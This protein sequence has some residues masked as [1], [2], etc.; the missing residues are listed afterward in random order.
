MADKSLAKAL[1]R[2]MGLDEGIL[3]EVETKRGELSLL[4]NPSRRRIFEFICNYPCSHLRA[5]S[6]EV[7]LST[8]SARWHINKLKEGGLISE[9]QDGSKKIYRPLKNIFMPDECSVFCLLS[10]EN[11]RNT[12]LAIEA[13]PKITQSDLCKILGTYQ[14]ILSR[15]L[16][17]LENAGII[18]YKKIGRKKAYFATEKIRELEE[19]LDARSKTFERALIDALKGDSLNPKVES[20]DEN[21]LQISLDI[22]R[23]EKPVLKIPKNPL[24]VLLRGG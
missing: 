3:R 8:Q 12:Y 20:S 1:R 17:S 9:S 14:Q 19:D 11:T 23:E 4:M 2:K 22:D 13:K 18:S 16:L 21:I 5:I 10:K 7:G 6:R 15:D 24:K